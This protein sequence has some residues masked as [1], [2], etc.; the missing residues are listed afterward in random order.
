MSDSFTA[1][2]KIWKN[3]HPLNVCV[4]Y[5]YLPVARFHKILILNSLKLLKYE[6]LNTGT[7]LP[8]NANETGD[9]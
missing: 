6:F 4:F 3:N 5:V 2:V 9:F 7:E 8:W 1:H